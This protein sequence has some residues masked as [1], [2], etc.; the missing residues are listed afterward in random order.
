MYSISNS[1]GGRPF[2]SVVDITIILF[3]LL[4][5]SNMFRRGRFRLPLRW[6]AEVLPL[7]DRSVRYRKNE[8]VL[9]EWDERMEA[10]TLSFVVREEIDEDAT[11]PYGEARGM[12]SGSVRSNPFVVST[13]MV[14]DDVLLGNP[15][16]S[17][18]LEVTNVPSSIEVPV[19]EVSRDGSACA[20]DSLSSLPPVAS[21]VVLTI[22]QEKRE[23]RVG[24]KQAEL[25]NGS[26]GSVLRLPIG[27]TMGSTDCADWNDPG[28]VG[29]ER[30]SSDSGTVHERKKGILTIDF[31]GTPSRP[32]TV[33]V[34]GP[35]SDADGNEPGS[36]NSCADWNDPGIVGSKRGSRDSGSGHVR[37]NGSRDSGSGHV[38]KKGNSTIDFSTTPS[39]PCT[40]I[41]PGP[42][43]DADGNKP[44]NANP[45]RRSKDSDIV[46]GMK[47]GE[48]HMSEDSSTLWDTN[49]ATLKIDPSAN[50]CSAL[51]TEST[52]MALGV[53]KQSKIHFDRSLARKEKDPPRRGNYFEGKRRS[54]AGSNSM[55]FQRVREEYFPRNDLYTLEEIRVQNSELPFEMPNF[56]VE[57]RYR[58]VSLPFFDG[59]G[60]CLVSEPHPLS[61]KIPVLCCF[62][63]KCARNTI[64]PLQRGSVVFQVC[65]VFVHAV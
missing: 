29:S 36:A 2:Q 26:L 58:M 23:M 40:V 14:S 63:G 13:Q 46:C 31:S 10:D 7:G 49:K 6:E 5:N 19:A 35:R 54:L 44:G 53:D 65:F 1:Y 24:Y 52:G 8:A 62:C 12:E 33:I 38:R 39:R 30:G 50:G 45:R 61:L 56:V 60:S 51:G 11:V 20:R 3:Y 59:C 48:K 9:R 22:A 43:S 34:P 37:K 21:A 55:F 15:N 17:F 4:W 32:C 27:S 28:I 47:R 64:L 16:A 18:G 25:N 41:V 57:E 42:R